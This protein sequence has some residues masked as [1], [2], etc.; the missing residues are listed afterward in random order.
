MDNYPSTHIPGF[1]APIPSRTA[2]FPPLDEDLIEHL[3]SIP[4]VHPGVA[5][6]ADGLR[7]LA[8]DKLT[9]DQTQTIITTLSG[10]DA[11]V[12][13]AI[14]LV[15]QRLTNPDTNPALDALTPQTAK[16]VQQLGEQFAYD[17]A[18]LHPGDRLNEAAAR[19]V[20]I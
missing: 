11:N 2:E 1:A 13:A 4:T 19:I 9:A 14:G 3:D 15:V 18:V 8:V 17:L 6:I 10:A 5:M 12:L 20:G 7:L 16:D